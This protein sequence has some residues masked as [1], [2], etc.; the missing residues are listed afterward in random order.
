MKHC[1]IKLIFIQSLLLQ[2]TL[3]VNKQLKDSADIIM[4]SIIH[5]TFSVW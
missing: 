1:S 2:D 3:L 4:T 5:S